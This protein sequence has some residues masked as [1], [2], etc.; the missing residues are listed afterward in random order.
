MPDLATA[1]LPRGAV[2]LNGKLF[3]GWERWEVANNAHRSADS[4]AISLASALLPPGYGIDWFAAQTAITV[5]IFANTAPDDPNNYQPTLADRLILGQVDDID[6]DPVRGLLTLTGR[7]FTAQLIDTSVSVGYLN[8]TSSQIAATLAARHDLTP[9]I[10]QTTT[11]IGTFYNQNHISLTQQRSEWDLL[12]ELAGFENFDAFVIGEELHFEPRPDPSDA[13]RYSIDWQPAGTTTTV[14]GANVTTLRLERSLTLARGVSVTVQSWHARLGKRFTA[15]WPQWD[16]D[17]VSGTAPL[18]YSFIAAG[19]TQDQCQQIARS[20][21]QDIA[22]HMMRLSA[23]LPGDDV[24]DCR[25]IL[26]VNGTGT[27]WDQ[28]YFPDIVRR[29]M[30]VADGYRMS[31]SAKNVGAA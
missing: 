13:E 27:S 30:S 12:T 8:Q 15:T 21:Y 22:Q 23:E 28:D 3:S 14:S 16:T 9:V 4:F 5:E 18:A 29:S 26:T 1:R 19:L 7:D 25:M 6:F 20:R 31:V 10:T 24:L 11:P 2:R 17:I